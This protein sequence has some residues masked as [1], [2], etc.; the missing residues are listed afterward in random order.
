MTTA[1]Y[2]KQP[3]DLDILELQGQVREGTEV[4]WMEDEVYFIKDESGTKEAS[5]EAK[6]FELTE[7]EFLA[8]AE[9]FFNRRKKAMVEGVKAIEK[10][11]RENAL[12]DKHISELVSSV[13]YKIQQ[14]E[15]VM[16]AT[17]KSAEALAEVTPELVNEA[18]IRGITPEALAI[19]ILEQLAQVKNLESYVSGIAGRKIDEIEKVV[20]DVANLKD[21]LNEFDSYIEEPNEDPN[22]PPMMRPKYNIMEGWNLPSV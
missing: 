20:F 3:R 22:L 16:T 9:D 11:I 13:A 12:S 6:F 2:F 7:T 21:C 18:N 19:K 5:E 15:I 8:L 1:K 10:Q 14:A 17:D 4:V